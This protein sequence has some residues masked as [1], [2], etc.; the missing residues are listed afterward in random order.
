MF[1][2]KC[3][4]LAGVFKFGDAGTE[5][6]KLLIERAQQDGAQGGQLLGF[7][8]ALGGSAGRGGVGIAVAGHGGGV[9]PGVSA[10]LGAGG[11]G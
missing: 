4:L 11:W 5:G 7:H 1:F 2:L 9:V 10:A 6:F 3:G 8:G